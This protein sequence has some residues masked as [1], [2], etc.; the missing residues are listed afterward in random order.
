MKSATPCSSAAKALFLAALATAAGCGKTEESANSRPATVAAARAPMRITVT[1]GGALA[2]AKPVVVSSEMEGKSTIIYL[3]PEGSAVKPGDVVVRLDAADLK[4]KLNK[5]EIDV[6]EAAATADA[7]QKKH[8]I[9]QSQNDSDIKEAE[10]KSKLAELDLRKYLNGE[11]PQEK[12]KFESDKKIAEEE[13]KRA[14]DRFAWS[15]KLFDKQFITKTE[16]EADELA[17]T[18]AKLKIDLADKALEVL[19]LYERERQE[20]KLKAE[21]E[22]AKAEIDRVKARA[23]AEATKTETDMRTKART[24]ELA[25]QRFADMQKQLEKSVI[26]AP[27]AGYVVYQRQD[28][29]RMGTEPMAEGKTVNEREPILQI[30]DTRFMLVDVDVHESLVKKV[31]A[32]QKAV[33]RIDAL[34]GKSFEGVVARVSQVPSTANSWMNPDLK[35]YPTQVEIT[36]VID[37]MKPGMNAQV[38]I[39]VAEM[40][41][42]LQAPIQAIHES[43]GQAFAYVDNGGAADLRP[44]EIGLDNGRTVE[45][46]SGLQ[47]GER[48][49]LSLPA[50]APALPDPDTERHRGAATPPTDGAPPVE[51]TPPMPAGAPGKRPEGGPPGGRRPRGDGETP[52]PREGGGEGPSRRREGRKSEG[53]GEGSAP[54]KTGDPPAKPKEQAR[55]TVGGASA[56]QEAK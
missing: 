23:S 44:I 18:K 46:K 38:E 41:S 10:L 2:S 54:T 29:G 13:L 19:E 7:A 52:T 11:Y 6:E 16:L 25:K 20:Q 26:T 51:A 22:E 50:G 8:L 17:A 33:V 1:E 45:I 28:R 53:A 30:P 3:M 9:Q 31:R 42:A 36:G 43:G 21:Y 32:G 37:E 49:F 5:Q 55:A 39:Q 27:A 14:E 48:V 15:K 56:G 40:A 34:P 4:E 47:E 24:A 12:L 35:T